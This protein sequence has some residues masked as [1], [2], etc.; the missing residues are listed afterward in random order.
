MNAVLPIAEFMRWFE[1]PASVQHLLYQPWSL[2]TYMFIHNGFMHIL[3]NMFALYGF[4]RIFLNFY[5]IRHFIGVYF[6]G[7]I[8]GGLFFIL[9]YN[10]FPYFEPL[11]DDSY[12]VG[13]SAA[14]MAIV[15]ASAVRTPNTV[16]NLMFFG[17]VR[18]AT[19][20]TITVIIS[21][22]L[23]SS[24]NAGGNFAHIGGV[25]AGYMFAFLL[26]KGIDVTNVINTPLDW[27]KRLFK[28]EVFKRKR[29]PKFTYT[30]NAKRGA[31]YEYNARRKT[32]EAEIDA[33]LEKL[34]KGGYSSL[35]E[36]EKKRL[37]EASR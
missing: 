27:I 2:V 37:F 34:K 19:L 11:V 35:T 10:I 26:G 25:L 22:L 29:K 31:D 9:A 28:G 18:L 16:V 12:L 14:V 3:W 8:V 15:V 20:A 5:S 30:G 23:L 1:L 21:I 33:I 36:A 32:S 17:A 24:E 7:G 6:F 13:A 4:G